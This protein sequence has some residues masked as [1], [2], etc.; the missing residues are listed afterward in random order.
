MKSPPQDNMVVDKIAPQTFKVVVVVLLFL[1][2]LFD[3]FV[4][5][6]AHP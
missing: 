5:M 2:V 3:I 1:L 6:S 4:P